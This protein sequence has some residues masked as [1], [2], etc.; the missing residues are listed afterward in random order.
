M[1]E[2]QQLAAL[3]DNYTRLQRIKSALDREE[4]IDYQIKIVKEKLKV[5]GVA[6]ENLNID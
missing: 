3:I 5:Y 4:E 2:K 6:A 1:D